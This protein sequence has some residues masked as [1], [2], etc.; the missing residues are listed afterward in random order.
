MDAFIN[1]KKRA[2]PDRTTLS[3]LLA[4]HGVKA[5]QVVVELNGQV[6]DR[7]RLSETRIAP[8]DAVEIVHFVGGG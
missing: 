8:E 5:E 3:D 2:F 4:Q 6:V 7:V 1:G